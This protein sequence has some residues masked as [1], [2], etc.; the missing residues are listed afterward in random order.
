MTDRILFRARAWENTISIQ[1]YTPR[2]KSPQRF[3]ITYSELDRLQS[4]GS[5]ISN[6]IH[7]FAVLRLDERRDRITFEFTWLTGRGFDR[8]EGVEQTVRL[9]WSAFRAFL[10]T[11]LQPDGLKD[12]KAISLDVSRR[13][14]L[15]FDGNQANLR[16]AIGNA[17]VR[18][19][20][21]KA[22]MTN[23]D[24]PDADEIH[25]YNDFTPYSFFFR[26]F[27]GEK[28]CLCGGLIL[29]G[30]EDM[31]KAYYGIHT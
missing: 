8:V 11:C 14:R 17:Q 18:H 28:S 25:L 27:R 30:Q 6:D 10:E 20:L 3:Y 12:F 13:P 26:E 4:E 9:R 22:L 7:S 21:G 31:S 24:W 16:A 29:H 23:F 5:I 1:T 19:K 15:V 2:M